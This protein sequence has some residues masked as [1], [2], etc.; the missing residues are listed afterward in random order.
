MIVLMGRIMAETEYKVLIEPYGT[1]ED[2]YDSEDEEMR[3]WMRKDKIETINDAPVE[4]HM[5]SDYVQTDE[6]LE[7][8]M[9]HQAAGRYL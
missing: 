2:W 1:Y 5:F 8:A 9:S 6:V 4:P 7:L 3:K